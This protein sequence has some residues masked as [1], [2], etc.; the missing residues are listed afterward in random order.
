MWHGI[1][2]IG[3]VTGLEGHFATQV[4]DRQECF[5]KKPSATNPNDKARPSGNVF[6]YRRVIRDKGFETAGVLL[7]VSV[8]SS[9]AQMLVSLA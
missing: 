7:I 5:A 9:C 1:K 8:A 4:R 2:T 6:N 3:F